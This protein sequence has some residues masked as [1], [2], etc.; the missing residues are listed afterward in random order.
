MSRTILSVVVACL[1]GR[2]SWAA[3][4]PPPPKTDDPVPR[5]TAKLL[6]HRKIQIELKMTAEQRITLID[7]IAEIEEEYDKKLADVLQ[8]PDFPQELFEKVLKDQRTAL[9]KAYS[10]SVQ[11]L[12]APQRRRLRQIDWHLR[13]A[14]AFT[15]PYVQE[16]L[17]LTAEQKKKAA[18]IA[19]QIRGDLQRH[20]DGLPGA[21]GLTPVKFD[22]FA[23]RKDRLKEMERLLSD[24]QK[25]AWK[26]LLGP[27]PTAF[28]VD[29]MWLYIE[30]LEDHDDEP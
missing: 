10:E 30:E 18:E 15:D 16:R 25:T 5:A 13:G 9:H 6:Q 17:Q 21:D 11:S 1:F 8:M 23:I 22:L 29:E 4:V 24:E 2:L 19:E 20:F 7:R 14:A 3:P 28:N 12:T 27:P 26:R